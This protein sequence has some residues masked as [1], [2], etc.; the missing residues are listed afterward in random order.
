M[1]VPGAFKKK[2]FGKKYKDYASMLISNTNKEEVEIY[3]Q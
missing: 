2:N 1:S 3:I